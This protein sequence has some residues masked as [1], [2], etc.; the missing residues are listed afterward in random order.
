[1]GLVR[2]KERERERER[3]REPRFLCRPL[4]R[5]SFR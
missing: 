5:L 3:E 2:G 1:M 4:R